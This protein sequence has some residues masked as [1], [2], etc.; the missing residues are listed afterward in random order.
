M[1][2]TTFNLHIQLIKENSMLCSYDIQAFYLI[3]VCYYNKV[4]TA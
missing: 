3:Q 4:I 1:E 2:V